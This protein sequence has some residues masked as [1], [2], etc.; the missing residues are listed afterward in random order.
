MGSLPR[1]RISDYLEGA[2][3]RGSG[4]NVEEVEVIVKKTVEATVA[5]L[6]RGIL[7]ELR[8][9]REEVESISQRLGELE[10]AMRACRQQSTR[11][12]RERRG[13][14]RRSK[15][16]EKLLEILDTE[17]YVFASK[18]REKIGVSPYRLREIALDAGAKIIELEGDFAVIDPR[19]YREF[20]VILASTRTSDPGEASKSMGRYRE[21]FEK[22]RASSLIYYDASRGSWRVLE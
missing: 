12:P 21:L 3:A 9:L 2:A 11:P 16:V 19:A 15:L 22:M 4:R 17:G 1:R 5:E 18:S 8:R 13:E 6:A 20:L 7:G 14:T 10:N